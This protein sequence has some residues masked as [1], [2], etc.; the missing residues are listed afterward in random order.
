VTGYYQIESGKSL[1]ETFLLH[2]TNGSDINSF[3]VIYD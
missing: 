2:L 3:S 1:T